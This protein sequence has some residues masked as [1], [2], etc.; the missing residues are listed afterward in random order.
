MSGNYFIVDKRPDQEKCLVYFNVATRPDQEKCQVYFN[1]DKRP[2]QEKCQVI[3]IAHVC[4]GSNAAYDVITVMKS[5]LFYRRNPIHFHVISDNASYNILHQ[6]FATWKK[7]NLTEVSVSFYPADK[8]K[9]Y[10][11]W[12][13]NKHH[14]GV[15][16]LMKLS[17][18]EILPQELNKVIFLDTDVICFADIAGLWKL[19]KHMKES[20][21]LGLSENLSGWYLGQIYENET[22][23]AVDKGYN[24]GV[25]LLNLK[26]L[27][28][29][30]WM[31][32]WKIVTEKQL[33]NYTFTQLGDQDVIN[34]VIKENQS[35]LYRIPCHWNVQ[36]KQRSIECP[37]ELTSYK[38]VHWNS[39]SKY[40]GSSKTADFFLSLREIFLRYNMI[41]IMK[42]TVLCNRTR[43]HQIQHTQR[44]QRIQRTHNE[45]KN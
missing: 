22:W 41:L 26:E 36:L 14:S 34:A 38:I 5:V 39:R 9:S 42:K 33:V 45:F 15:N 40:T 23:P 21:V 18:T 13:P 7:G 19:F 24:T 27:R 11:S 25:M 6:Q 4:T 43:T 2:D 37:G 12:I 8:A 32:I 20:M 30:N 1:V 3:H 10:V 29:I 31:N 17:L 28:S 44:I 35:L 16:G